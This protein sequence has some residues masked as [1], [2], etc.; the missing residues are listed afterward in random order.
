MYLLFIACS[1]YNFIP[2][3]DAPEPVGDVDAPSD[4]WTDTGFDDPTPDTDPDCAQFPQDWTWQASDTIWDEAD[5][6]DADGLP[7]WEPQYADSFTSIALPDA[8]QVPA[9]ADRAYRSTF[10]LDAV[11]VAV[12][13]DL[14]SD[15]GVWLWV[16]GALIGHWGGDFQEEGCVNDQANCLEFVVIEP[17]DI[18][19]WLSEG[20]NLV[21][22]RVS[23]AVEGS[24]FDLVPAC[25]D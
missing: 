7:F 15:D 12:E 6:T 13:V 5:P 24:W 19:E 16:N 2:E 22:A 25:I 20:D 17:V 11:P 9:G 8:H 14:Q 21:A 1:D 23:N 10:T 3:A 4:D 18:T